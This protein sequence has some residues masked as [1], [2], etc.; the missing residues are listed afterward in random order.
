MHIVYVLCQF[1]TIF[2][3]SYFPVACV[4]YGVRHVS[5]HNVLSFHHLWLV[6]AVELWSACVTTSYFGGWT[7][8]CACFI[9]NCI[10]R[11]STLCFFATVLSL[12][13]TSAHRLSIIFSSFCIVY[14]MFLDF[15]GHIHGQRLNWFQS[16]SFHCSLSFNF[17]LFS[18]L[19]WVANPSSN[20]AH[21]FNSF[22]TYF[23]N[24]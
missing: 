23:K 12:S 2:P 16:P 11:G 3:F 19:F 1:G 10:Y 7:F 8:V 6:F 9:S 17:W 20:E 22:I 5:H 18:I 21:H 15:G 13:H 14:S 4:F 24:T